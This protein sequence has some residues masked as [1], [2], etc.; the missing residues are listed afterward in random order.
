MWI[1]I[2]TIVCDVLGE[3]NNGTTIAAMNL[4]RSLRAKGHEVRILCPDKDRQ[5][6][7]GFY[8][9]PTINLGVFN[10][11]VRKNGV[12]IARADREVIEKAID[13]ADVV[14]VMVPFFLGRCA[15]KMAHEAGI[16]VS[17]GF[18]ALAENLTVHVFM[19]NSAGVNRMIYRFFAS[20]YE[21]CDAIHYPTQFLRD[22]YEGMYGKTNGY[23]ISNGVNSAFKPMPTQKPEEYRDKFVILFTGRYSGEKS[24]KVLIDAVDLSKHRDNIQLIFAGAGPKDE[25]LKKYSKKLPVYPRFEFFSREDMVKTVNSSDLYVHPAEIEAEGIACLEAIACGLVPVISNSPR[26]ATKAYAIDEKNLFQYDSPENLAEKID[27]WI[28]HPEEKELCRR[29][30]LEYA[31][32]LFNQEACMDRME[33]MLVETAEL[34]R[35]EAAV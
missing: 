19:K 6:R 18:H 32:R 7:E 33:R 31:G 17:A 5:G 26:C 30:Y 12:T 3:E 8:I 1:M 28:E 25:F 15:A 13:G 9:V 35:Q 14:H 34:R 11:Y 23:V 20:F 22:L 29:E 24:H 4:V 2:I 21:N 16:P 27:W 10:G